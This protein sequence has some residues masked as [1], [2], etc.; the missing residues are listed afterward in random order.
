MELRIAARADNEEQ[1]AALLAPV[2]QE[3]RELLG[4][5][6]SHSLNPDER[7]A[8]GAAAQGGLPQGGGKLAGATGA[9]A[10]GLVLM[11]LSLIHI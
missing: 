7:V 2:E 10:Q 8:M 1:A 9:A 11:D 4:G 6:P 5:E 3:V